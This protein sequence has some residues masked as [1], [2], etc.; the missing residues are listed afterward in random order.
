VSNLVHFINACYNSEQRLGL[1]KRPNRGFKESFHVGQM[2]GTLVCGCKVRLLQVHGVRLM[3]SSGS[4]MS[5]HEI[6]LGLSY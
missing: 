1:L 2:S 6:V 5:F 3:E 4:D